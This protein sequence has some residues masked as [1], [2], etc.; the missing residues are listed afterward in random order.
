MSNAGDAKMHHQGRTGNGGSAG[1]SP[2]GFTLVELLVVIGVIGLLIALLLPAVQAAREASRCLACKN[3]LKQVGLAL[4][5]YD[6]Q[7]LAFPPGSSEPYG[8]GLAWSLFI[9]PN[10]EQP[11]IF[12]QYQFD[13]SAISAAN[14]EATG[15]VIPVYLCPSTGR[16][17]DD[18][19]RDVS[20]DR[21]HNGQRDPGD[22]MG[23]IDYGGVHGF[24]SLTEAES[25]PNGVLPWNHPPGQPRIV[26]THANIRDGTSNTMMVAE[27]SGRG[28]AKGT[29]ARGTNVFDVTVSINQRQG[30]EIFSDHSGGA[31]GLFADGSVHFL[32]DNTDLT[33][34][35]ALCTR[36]GGESLAGFLP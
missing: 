15:H 3:N 35:K 34:L 29:W 4:L 13:A 1:P 16:R 36:A 23:C 33:T 21:N 6:A 12:N 32:N 18:R 7:H 14:M 30:D 8:Q 2:R 11:A 24:A 20:W 17:M 5:N 28:F 10:L 19:D 9:L 22:A 27:S 26:V 31:N 25:P